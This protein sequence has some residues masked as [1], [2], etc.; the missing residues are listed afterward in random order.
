MWEMQLLQVFLMYMHLLLFE[1]FLNMIFLVINFLE[2]TTLVNS[3]K[4]GHLVPL[5]VQVMHQ[6]QWR[7]TMCLQRWRALWETK[8][9]LGLL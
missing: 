5:P 9:Q 8:T 3:L 6:L 1:D 2:T 7:L 4:H